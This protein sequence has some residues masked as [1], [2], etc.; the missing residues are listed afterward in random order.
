MTEGFRVSADELAANA[1]QFAGLA[2]RVD[3]IHRDLADRLA[4]LGECWGA[5]AI[6]QSFGAVHAVPADEALTALGGLAGKLGDV[7]ERFT[8][9]AGAY[10]EGEQD[11]VGRLGL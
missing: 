11:N 2:E 4:A 9:N 6:G 5:D 7:G 10:T 8:A 1:G 3:T